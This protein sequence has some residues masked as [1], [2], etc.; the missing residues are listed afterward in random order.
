MAPKQQ[1]PMDFQSAANLERFF[2]ELEPIE[3]LFADPEFTYLLHS[4]V[5]GTLL[6]S[7]RLVFQPL[8]RNRPDR[9]VDVAGFYG[10]SGQLRSLKVSPRD[11]IS[12]LTSGI[13]AGPDRTW[14]LTQDHSIRPY[15]FPRNQT[16]PV[17]AQQKINELLGF[18]LSKHYRHTDADDW[19]LRS[20]EPPYV[21]FNDLFS[22]LGLNPQER[23][24]I[25]S[26][27]PLVVDATSRVRGEVA[28]LKLF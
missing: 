1:E 20:A 4:G 5:N 15:L 25:I 23:L 28:E 6:V 7:A 16:N 14:R 18:G 17:D 22:D 13:V 12:N 24:H 9:V 8:P 10:F 27:P 11:L 2:Q 21:L 26:S 3:A 19:A